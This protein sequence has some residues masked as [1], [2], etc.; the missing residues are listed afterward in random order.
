MYLVRFGE[1]EVVGFSPY[2][3]DYIRGGE[4][5]MGI[6]STLYYGEDKA[7]N[8]E[9]YLSQKYNRNDGRVVDIDK[10]EKAVKVL[11]AFVALM[12]E[13]DMSE[14]SRLLSL[15]EEAREVLK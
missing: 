7:I 14:V 10:G 5:M 11:E 13:L 6:D 8:C 1:K 15:R 3:E 12:D 9:K 4:N 2:G